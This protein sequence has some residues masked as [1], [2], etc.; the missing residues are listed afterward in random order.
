MRLR[1]VFASLALAGGW[2]GGAH[3]AAVAPWGAPPPAPIS[4]TVGWDASSAALDCAGCLDVKLAPAPVGYRRTSRWRSRHH[5][6]GRVLR[7]RG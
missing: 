4:A 7:V 1:T 2:A 3:A 5:R 6:H